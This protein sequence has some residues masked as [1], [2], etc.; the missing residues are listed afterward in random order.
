MT[1]LLEQAFA[2]AKQLPEAEQDA[3]AKMLLQTL[4]EWEQKEMATPKP[5][6]K[7]GSA[8]GIGYMMP[9]FDEILEDFKDY[10]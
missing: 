4:N 1:A 8:R 10:M 3:A 7:A 2:K 5:R 6:R 9:D